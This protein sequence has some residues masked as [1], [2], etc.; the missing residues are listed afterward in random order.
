MEWQVVGRSQAGNK[1]GVFFGRLADAVVYVDHGE[2]DAQRVPLLEQAP[3]QGHGISPAGDRDGDSLPRPK[4]TAAESERGRLHGCA[5]VT[6]G[7]PV[8]SCLVDEL[9]AALFM[10]SRIRGGRSVP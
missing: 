3:Q 8:G 6:A 9:R 1:C 4:K 2:Y 10:K 7:F 5:Y